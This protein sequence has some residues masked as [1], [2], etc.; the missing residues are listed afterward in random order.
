M[1]LTNCDNIIAPATAAG[2]GAI[3]IIR[4]SGPDCIAVADSLFH[5]APAKSG[6]AISL[7]DSESRKLR[8]G[9]ICETDDAGATKILDDVM[10]AIFR[11]PQSYTGEDCV[12]IYC[13]ASQYIMNKLLLL[14]IDK[15][16]L[17]FKSGRVS[18]PLRMASPGEFTQLA[19]INGKMDLAQAEAVAD[20]IASET[21]AAH[22]VAMNQMR[23]GYSRELKDMRESLLNLASLME[24]ELDFSEEDVEFADRNRLTE[25]LKAIDT[26]LTELIESFSLGNVIKNGIPVAIVGAV[27]TGKST[28]LNALVGEERAI[29]SDIQG[30]TRDT[31]EDT[32]N[33]A[34]NTF[35]FIDTAGIRNTTETIEILGI[36]RT[37]QKLKESSIII[38]MLDCARKENFR[39]S[40]TSISERIDTKRQR[41]IIVANKADTIP[42][43]SSA[44]LSDCRKASAEDFATSSDCDST[45][46]ASVTDYGNTPAVHNNTLPD[47][48]GSTIEQP[49]TSPDCGEAAAENPPITTETI[50]DEI[51]SICKEL[52]LNQVS[53]FCVSLKTEKDT[54]LER[55]KS[56]LTSYGSI[57]SS[58]IGGRC[59]VTNARHY[60]A[61]IAART[62]LDTVFN[63]LFS[64]LPTDL[65]AQDIREAIDNL[66]S[67]VGEISS[68]DILN[69]IFSHFCIGK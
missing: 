69:N 21:E 50:E 13:H 16:R 22:D 2:K 44:T 25:L 28:L 12:E 15:A 43:T 45:T 57:F 26:K 1:N 7:K 40:I 65:L 60:Q 38:L 36:E 55:I 10:A 33:F 42:A 66:G 19:F 39:E 8:Y 67:I 54:A 53:I 9:T 17:L 30:T 3:G 47:N 68:Q 24:L 62:S 46:S 35:R 52:T 37:Y 41:L 51:S 61:L 34:G 56:A 23:G 32:V 4:L 18:S 58:N 5:P 6:K 31:I 14:F 48:C 20:L 49:V 63:G 59:L 27:N 11:A 64:D 29:V